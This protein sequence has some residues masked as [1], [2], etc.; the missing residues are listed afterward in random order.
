MGLNILSK[1]SLTGLY[2]TE[3]GRMRVGGLMSGSGSNLKK[4]IE[5]GKILD[6]LF[7]SQE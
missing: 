7:G 5:H 2:N 4:I 1:M 6:R 3:Q